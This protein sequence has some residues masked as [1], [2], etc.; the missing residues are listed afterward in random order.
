MGDPLDDLAKAIYGAESTP[1]VYTDIGGA[2]GGIPLGDLVSKTDSSM[3][4]RA[5]AQIGLSALSGLFG[6]MGEASQARTSSLFND[7]ASAYARGGSLEDPGLGSKLFGK[8]KTAGQLFRLQKAEELLDERRKL[9]QTMGLKVF[10]SLLQRDLENMKL[11]RGA[12]L[13]LLKQYIINP[14]QVKATLGEDALSIILGQGELPKM[15]GVSS[16]R[17]VSEPGKIEKAPEPTFPRVSIGE[18]AGQLLEKKKPEERYSEVLK[19][20]GGA[21]G[22]SKEIVGKELSRDIEKTKQGED[23]LKSLREAAETADTILFDIKSAFSKAGQT[24]GVPIFEEPLRQF[25]L[26][27][28]SALG[29]DEAKKRLAGRRDLNDLATTYAST[30]RRLFPG[31]TSEKELALYL[32]ASPG[33]HRTVQENA[34][35][36]NRLERARALAKQKVGF[37]ETAMSLGLD[38]NQALG[39]FDRL[40]EKA[41]KFLVNEKGE[42]DINPTRMKLNV[43]NPEL[44]KALLGNY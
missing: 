23:D 37:L 42:F 17:G 13:D 43:R 44:I 14:E 2:I 9:D 39:L 21:E 1:N 40:E 27:T 3:G 8:A 25:K 29:S 28:E 4:E 19:K 5:I 22:V 20:T 12:S 16:R 41:P 31:P 11:N 15:Q 38:Y 35:A 7:V 32:G 18:S 26:R 36:V 30:I 33:T 34:V 24:G 6:G 10:D